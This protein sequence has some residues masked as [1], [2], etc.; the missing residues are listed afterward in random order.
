LL[1]GDAASSI[2]PL[3]SQGLE[4]A[5]ASAEEA[6]Y[7]INTIFNTTD[8]TERLLAHHQAWERGLFALHARR[9]GDFYA[10]ES[11]F[12]AEPF[13]ISRANYETGARSPS[14][15]PD[16]LRPNHGV[17]EATAFRRHHRLL[18]PTRGFQLG[19]EGEIHHHVGAIPV[20]AL[21]DLLAQESSTES[22]LQNAGDHPQLFPLSRGKVEAALLELVRLGLVEEA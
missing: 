3:S 19:Q 10:T 15:L 8:Q 18:E 5:L 12:I 7:V 11:R 2:D 13:W 6:A 21:M 14:R 4:K 16:T 9:S 17:L 1:V 22:V 20:A